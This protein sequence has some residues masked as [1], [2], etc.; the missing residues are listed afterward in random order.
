MPVLTI[1]GKEYDVRR[2]SMLL[3]SNVLI[4][5]FS[6]TEIVRHET[7]RLLLEEDCPFL[8]PVPVVVEAWGLLARGKAASQPAGELVDWL[9]SSGAA[10]IISEDMEPFY[11]LIEVM[12]RRRIDLVDSAV[13]RLALKITKECKLTPPI[14]IATFDTRDFLP[15]RA[16][17]RGFLLYDLNTFDLI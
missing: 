8:V 5:A 1:P 16:S 13:L 7:A 11:D 12:K 17:V 14:K 2:D 4:A 9:A 15:L 3:D 6:P 10:T